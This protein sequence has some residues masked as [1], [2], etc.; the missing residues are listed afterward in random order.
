VV[1]GV[2]KGDFQFEKMEKMT[3]VTT[4]WR[5]PSCEPR[6]DTPLWGLNFLLLFNIV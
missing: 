3:M 6:Q 2:R 4:P 5:N 1:P